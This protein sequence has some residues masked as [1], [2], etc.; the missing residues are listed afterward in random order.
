LYRYNAAKQIMRD[1]LPIKCVE[2]VFL[3]LH[4][5]MGWR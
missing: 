1:A 2:A 4:L 3:A 5:T